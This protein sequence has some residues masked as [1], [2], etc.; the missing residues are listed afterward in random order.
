MGR[1]LAPHLASKGFVVTA[2]SRAEEKVSGESVAWRRM[3]D[4]GDPNADWEALLSNCEIV[5]HLAGLAHGSVDDERHDA[6]NRRGTERLV[7]A[8]VQ[9]GVERF[10]FV[11]SVAA[12]AGAASR[13]LIRE[14]DDPRPVNAYGRSKLAAEKA[15]EQSGMAFTILRPVAIYGAG[16]KG[17]TAGLERIADLPVPLPFATLNAPRSLLSIENFCSAVALVLTAPQ[18]VNG[19]FLVA[20][21]APVSVAEFIARRRRRT[22]RP[23]WLY[24]VPPAMIKWPLIALGQGWL[25]TRVGEPMV[26]SVDR[27]RSIGWEPSD[28]DAASPLDAGAGSP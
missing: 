21:P 1:C 19:V 6:I 7:K 27:L 3:P 10:V 14:T 8:A 26:V 24:A 22:G 25:W 5:V 20:D 13:S 4:I 18:A 15:V 16:A 28:D 11:S 17:N 12:Q 23:A 2:A 9:A